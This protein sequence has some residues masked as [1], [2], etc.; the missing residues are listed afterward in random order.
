MLAKPGPD[1]EIDGAITK[2][3]MYPRSFV[4]ERRK[5]RVCS[6]LLYRY[7]CWCYRP[8]DLVSWLLMQIYT[9]VIVFG[10]ILIGNY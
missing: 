7:F 10:E 8:S 5:E 4:V 6:W 3:K 2:L 9:E 1:K